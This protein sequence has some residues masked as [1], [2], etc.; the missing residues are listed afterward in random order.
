MDLQRVSVHLSQ[1]LDSDHTE[2]V[3]QARQI[4]IASEDHLNAKAIR[5]AILV[6]GGYASQQADAI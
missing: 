1:L 4:D 3:R 2:A 6:E 5:A